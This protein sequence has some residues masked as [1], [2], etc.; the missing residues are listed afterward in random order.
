MTPKLWTPPVGRRVNKHRFASDSRLDRWFGAEMLEQLRDASRQLMI[1]TPI[2]CTPKGDAIYAVQ[3]H[4]LGAMRGGAFSSLSDL[5]AEAS[6]GKR[7]DR[8]VFKVGVTGV[9]AN[10]SSLWRVGSLPNVPAAPSALAGGNLLDNTTDG[11]I[12]QED[13][14]GGDTLHLISATFQPTSGGNL[15]LMYDRLWHGLIAS[16]TGTQTCTLTGYPNGAGRYS[17]APGEATGNFV[18][19]CN[20]SGSGGAAF[21]AVGHNWTLV[22]T[23]DA[24]NTA[25]SAAALAGFSG[26]IAQRVDHAGF[27]IPLLA[28]DYGVADVESIQSS[29]S[30]AA[31]TPV[32]ALGHPLALIPQ[33][34]TAVPWVHDGLNTAFNLVEIKTDACIAF[35]EVTKGTTTATSYAGQ[36][37][38]VS[39]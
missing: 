34:I 11:G 30:I 7:Q 5:I 10:S 12:E 24:G 20:E 36:I 1:P 15:L 17:G 23:D 37:V 28:G 33:P 8:M 29:G 35:M 3:G 25:Q 9:V 4:F 26:C 2:A 13:P 27:C 14:A 22:Y 19:I 16:G 31:G 38:M 32:I 6:G 39:G 18:F 21:S